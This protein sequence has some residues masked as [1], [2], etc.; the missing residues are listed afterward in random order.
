MSKT[1]G[2]FIDSG[3]NAV[4]LGSDTLPGTDV[5]AFI[6]GSTGDHSSGT[7]NRGTTLIG[8]DLVTSGAMYGKQLEY[9][10]HCYNRS[11]ADAIFIGW[12]NNNEATGNIDDVQGV[13]PFGGRPVRVIV[14]PQNDMGL[15]AVGFHKSTAGTMYVGTTPIESIN[16]FSAA[17][18]TPVAFDFTVTGSA[19]PTARHNA[20]DV[21]AISINPSNSPG[22]CNVTVIWELMTHRIIS[23]SAI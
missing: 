4:L 10:Y 8:G 17:D 22:D 7:A 2:L 14:R 18:A 1:H 13:M 9:T 16:N 23:G 21:V 12:Y 19:A 3:N 15:T 11:N 20:G 5:F 6:S